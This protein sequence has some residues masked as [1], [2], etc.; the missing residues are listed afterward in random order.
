MLCWIKH[1]TEHW[2]HDELQRRLRGIPEQILLKLKLPVWIQHKNIKLKIS[3]HF[4]PLQCFMN[5]HEADSSAPVQKISFYIS[6]WKMC[7]VAHFLCVSFCM[8][9]C[10]CVCVF[11]VTL[12]QLVAPQPSPQP[13]RVPSSDLPSVCGSALCLFC[14]FSMLRLYM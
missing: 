3:L 1:S 12:K 8:C 4:F 7:C 11:K 10:E 9:V 5:G 13:T 6:K 2:P 14:C